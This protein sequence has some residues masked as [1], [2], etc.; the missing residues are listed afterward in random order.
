MSRPETE[1]GSV[2]SARDLFLMRNGFSMASYGAA[3]VEIPLGPI[4]ARIP[5]TEGR[6]AVV[7]WHDLHHVITGYGTDLIGEAEIGMWELRAG[8]TTVAAYVLNTM[9]VALGLLLAPKR[10]ARAFQRARGAQSLYRQQLDYD[11]VLDVSVAALR[12]MAAVPEEGVADAP[13]RL[14]TAAR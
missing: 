6:K 13:P 5:N 10:V 1:D 2:R 9:A 11:D 3:F 8:C 12:R 4:T 7:P 14:H